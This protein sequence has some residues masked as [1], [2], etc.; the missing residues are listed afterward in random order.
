[1]DTRTLNRL[2]HESPLTI[3][4]GSVEE[5]GMRRY[6]YSL[7]NRETGE[8]HV[9]DKPY[10]VCRTVQEERVLGRL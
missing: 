8:V 1:M 4:T 2:C 9:R 3:E 7:V 6:A 5:D 10:G